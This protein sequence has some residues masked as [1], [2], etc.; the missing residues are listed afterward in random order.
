MNKYQKKKNYFATYICHYHIKAT[1]KWVSKGNF[2]K[3]LRDIFLWIK[4][5][6]SLKDQIYISTYLPS[7]LS[8]YFHSLE[9]SVV[10]VVF[11]NYYYEFLCCII[12]QE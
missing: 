7:L 1:K 12:F 8:I 2:G 6:V 5:D 3:Y 4:F 11:L 9:K 10:F